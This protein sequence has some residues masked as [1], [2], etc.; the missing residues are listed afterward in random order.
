MNFAVLKSHA[1]P[2]DIERAT[3][4]ATGSEQYQAMYIDSQRL[5]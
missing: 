1:D 3:G 5:G 4:S 2:A